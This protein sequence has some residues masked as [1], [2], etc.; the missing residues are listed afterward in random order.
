M[1]LTAFAPG[2]GKSCLVRKGRGQ[3]R[4]VRRKLVLV[5]PS[6]P[7]RAL[8]PWCKWPRGPPPPW[9]FDPR[10]WDQRK[11]TAVRTAYPSY[12]HLLSA[13]SFHRSCHGACQK[14]FR[15]CAERALKALPG[16]VS[17]HSCRD[18]AALWVTR[19]T[20]GTR[21][22]GRGRDVE[23]GM[24]SHVKITARGLSNLGAGNSPEP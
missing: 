21:G 6:L 23:N 24:P 5:G 19:Q 22:A 16:V 3:E 9:L 8:S 4:G 17:S 18:I 12:R 13:E 7:P 10:R 2:R 14:C 15:G 11:S 1:L 20:G